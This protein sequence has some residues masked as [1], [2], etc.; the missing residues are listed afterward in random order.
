MLHHGAARV[1]D[2]T[3]MTLFTLEGML[4]ARRDRSLQG[5]D[6]ISR[7]Y[8]DWLATQEADSKRKA[9]G[10]LCTEAVLQH[11]RAPGNTCLSALREGHPIE[12]SKGC[13]GVMRVAPLGLLRQRSAAEAFDSGA[14]AAALTH[15]HPT[16]YLSAG[17]FAGI[18]RAAVGGSDLLAATEQAE[19]ILTGRQGCEET[20]AATHA[21]LK[22]K[23]GKAL[24]AVGHL[25][26]GWIAEEALAIGL[27]CAIH[28][29][30]F[31]DAL[32]IAANHDGDSDSTA[33]I[34]GQL[35]GAAHGLSDLPNRWVRRL[36]VLVPLLRL[37]GELI[38][39]ESK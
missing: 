17:M 16:G 11:R 34:A 7:A 22:S 2:D 10:R 5:I 6:E 3:Q 13:G 14:A 32:V 38:E 23:R 18:I 24:P 21:A 29:R 25:G 1:S 31:T 33:S 20:V 27:Y 36:D 19:A 9:A 12:D 8:A 28:G 15:G 37:V 35:Y 39:L 4:R 26:E 30:S